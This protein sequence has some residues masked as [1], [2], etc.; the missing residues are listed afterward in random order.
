MWPVYA[1]GIAEHFGAYV[2]D[3]EAEVLSRAL[4]KVRAA[5]RVD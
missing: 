1:K 3:E 2:S 5:A 4:G